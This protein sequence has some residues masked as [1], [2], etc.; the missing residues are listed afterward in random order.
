MKELDFEVRRVKRES[1]FRK[2][3]VPRILTPKQRAA[4]QRRKNYL[5]RVKEAKRKNIGVYSLP[6]FW[7]IFNTPVAKRL[8]DLHHR[9]KAQS[10]HY[11]NSFVS[12]LK[13]HLYLNNYWPLSFETYV[14]SLPHYGYYVKRGIHSYTRMQN[15][16]TRLL[17]R[18]CE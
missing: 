16:K 6:R 14:E 15:M 17:A 12:P 2:N 1:R 5:K 18:N 10:V 11:F 4:I 3:K 13:Q 7:G 9:R 8:Y